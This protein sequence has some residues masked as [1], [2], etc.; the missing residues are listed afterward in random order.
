MWINVCMKTIRR[1][2]LYYEVIGQHVYR[3]QD[4][5]AK[6]ARGEDYGLPQILVRNLIKDSLPLVVPPVQLW[7]KNWAAWM[8]SVSLC[9][10]N[11]LLNKY[12]TFVLYVPLW[13]CLTGCSLCVLSLNLASRF[14]SVTLGRRKLILCEKMT[15]SPLLFPILNLNV[16]HYHLYTR[17][18][19]LPCLP[20]N[21]YLIISNYILTAHLEWGTDSSLIDDNKHEIH[22]LIYQCFYFSFIIMFF[23]FSALSI[24]SANSIM[25]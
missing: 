15:K 3:L 21:W 25:G 2:G 13:I 7:F 22:R 1:L 8:V 18:P 20:V 24:F 19:S 6:C 16:W 23:W 12:C 4:T 17:K 5:P 14:K 9:K 10:G 11:Y